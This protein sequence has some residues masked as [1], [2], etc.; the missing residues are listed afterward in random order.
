MKKIK[1]SVSI[2][3]WALPLCFAISIH[4]KSIYILCFS[5]DFMDA[6]QAYDSDLM[7][8]EK[9]RWKKGSL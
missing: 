9:K 6:L 4:M 8:A 1:V 2:R 7:E 3:Q 5:I